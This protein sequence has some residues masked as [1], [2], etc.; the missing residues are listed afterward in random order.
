M[1]SGRCGVMSGQFLAIDSDGVPV[2]AARRDRLHEPSGGD[3]RPL[4]IPCNCGGWF[5]LRLP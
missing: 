4:V 1:S 2:C 5:V 3:I